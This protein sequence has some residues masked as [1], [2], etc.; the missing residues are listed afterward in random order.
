MTTTQD[1]EEL[2]RLAQAATPGIWCHVQRGISR[3]HGERIEVDLNPICDFAMLQDCCVHEY[4]RAYENA[5]YIQAVNPAAIIGLIDTIQAQ[6]ERIKVLELDLDV[7]AGSIDAAKGVNARQAERIKAL[8]GQLD[9]ATAA[10]RS[11]QMIAET[12]QA[13]ASRLLT[14]RDNLRAQLNAIAATEPVG[15]VE[16]AHDM[17]DA[18]MRSLP[19][20]TKLFTR[21]M[22]AEIENVEPVIWAISYD[23]V[24]PYTLW[25]EGDGPL[26]DCE[27]ERQGGTTQKMPLFTRPM[28]AQPI[29]GSQAIHDAITVD[30]T[31]AD[32]SQD[33]NA[34]IEK[35][36]PVA[37]ALNTGTRQAVKWLQNIPHGEKLYTRPMPAQSAEHCLWARNGHEPCQHV[38]PMQDVTEL[39]EAL[40]KLARLGNGEHYGNSDGNMIARKALSKYKGA[41]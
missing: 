30:P 37:I 20:G 4:D 7:Q 24:T 33:V 27:V 29:I 12:A 36:E 41:K 40:E 16:I 39:V 15:K 35:V 6:A 32:C 13:A 19:I 8:E 10:A 22:P 26:L 2:R 5:A 21:P 3:W 28:P 18:F 25:H 9:D 38:K 34:E 14:E 23:G 31:L 1:I 11:D 17:N